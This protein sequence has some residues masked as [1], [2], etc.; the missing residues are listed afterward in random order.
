VTIPA[1]IK[2]IGRG[3]FYHIGHVKKYVFEEGSLAETTTIPEFNFTDNKELEEVVFP[4]S[5]IALT[6]TVLGGATKLNKITFTGENP[7]ALNSFTWN[8]KTYKVFESTL[9]SPGNPTPSKCIIEVPLHAA[10]TYVDSNDKFKE[11]PMS[12]KFKMNKEYVTFCSDL[13][14]TFKQYDTASK[15]WNDGDVKT[16]Y[17]VFDNVK[18][19]KVTLTE[20]TEA[21]KI[22]STTTKTNTGY[23]G[24]VLNG[25]ANETYDIF[26]PNNLISDELPATENCMQGVVKATRMGGDDP[27]DGTPYMAMDTEHNSYYVL[28]NGEFLSVTEPGTFGAHKAFL[29]IEGSPTIPSPQGV[30]GLSISLPDETT[31]ITTHEVQGAQNDAWYTLQGIQVK[32]PEKG[33]FIKNGKKYIIK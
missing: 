24:V 9:S 7:P 20:I 1:G 18:D 11:F 17:V 14:F 3:S 26:Y 32:N 13:P 29:K 8:N 23:F 31:G 21:K 25:T 16:Y 2:K 22:P 4:S 33:V 10:K 15:A 6:G 30:R 5:I 12:S 27:G 19:G 28:T